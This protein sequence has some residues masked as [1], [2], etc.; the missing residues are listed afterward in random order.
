MAIEVS[1]LATADRGNN[2]EINQAGQ[3]TGPV[4]PKNEF[5][6]IPHTAE[7]MPGVDQDR[8]H[9]FLSEED[10]AEYLCKTEQ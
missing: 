6:V 1:K 8:L 4:V 9:D 7:F 3:H 5:R 10:L 2:A